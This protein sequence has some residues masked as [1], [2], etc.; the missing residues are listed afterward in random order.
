MDSTFYMEFIF[1]VDNLYFKYGQTGIYHLI[2]YEQGTNQ[3]ARK[4]LSFG[5]HVIIP[6]IAYFYIV[7]A[8]YDRYGSIPLQVNQ[9]TGRTKDTKDVKEKVANNQLT[10]ITG[11]PGMGK[12]CLAIQV[13][14]ELVDTNQKLKACFIDLRSCTSIETVTK[15]ILHCFDNKAPEDIPTDQLCK[16]FC[17]LR[18]EILLIFDN[19][20]DLLTD[21]LKHD[22]LSV[23]EKILL[24]CPKLKILCTSRMRF[25]IPGINCKEH[26]LGP[27]KVNYALSF[28]V[29]NTSNLSI[30][31]ARNLAIL[32][33]CAPKALEIISYLLEDGGVRPDEL[34]REIDPSVRKPKMDTYHLHSPILD[35]YQLESCINSSY[36]RLSPTEQQ[37]FCFLSIFP[38][39]FDLQAACSIIGTIEASQILTSLTVRSLVT[40]ESNS[41]RYSFHSYIRFF[42][43]S[44]ERF[45]FKRTIVNFVTHYA[46]VLQKLT[47]KYYSRDFKAATREI[48]FENVNII[49]MLKLITE[50]SELYEIYKQLADK[51]V[52]RFIHAFIPHKEYVSFYRNLLEEAKERDDT[53]S[54]SLIYFCLGYYYLATSQ[55]QD[56]IVMLNDA[57]LEYGNGNWD[58]MHIHV[59]YSWLAR[60][61]SSLK[62]YQNL[63]RYFP[64]YFLGS[65]D[66]RTEQIK[67]YHWN[68]MKYVQRVD[69]FITEESSINP[70][71]LS[72]AFVLTKVASAFESLNDLDKSVKLSEEAL[73]YWDNLLGDHLDTARELLNLSNSLYRLRKWDEALQCSV[74]ASGIFLD[75][76]GKNRETASSLYQCGKICLSQ[77]NFRQ[78]SNF[79]RQAVEAQEITFDTLHE[80]GNESVKY[81]LEIVDNDNVFQR[82]LWCFLIILFSTFPRLSD[83]F[84][85]LLPVFSIILCFLI[86][87]FIVVSVFVLLYLFLR[88][89]NIIVRIALII[90]SKH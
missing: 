49:E 42:A 15:Q 31:D 35:N 89:L 85:L 50:E 22:F 34:I 7:E 32:C 4:V 10:V 19:S 28:L 25:R 27:L 81:L 29:N 74:R 41:D 21:D 67:L 52:V 60:C 13:G 54:C 14:R 11:A 3:I 43:K 18:R 77:R 8:E 26:A 64:E 78:A 83:I 48:Q 66:F 36:V 17:S 73:W 6:I 90:A 80:I 46:S 38:S 70:T 2:S 61:Y 1:K 57:V 72:M 45:D 30:H 33:G 82:Y 71:C 39:T 56:A 47:A 84:S 88:W 37:A 55:Y 62:T 86:I 12:T 68:A 59:C 23:T 79:L 69:D 58:K 76:I 44:R 87:I 5:N 20:E 51:F 53:K 24:K 40:Y 65:K 16:F 63:M 75:V 9:F